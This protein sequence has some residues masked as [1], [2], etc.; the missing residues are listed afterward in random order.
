MHSPLIEIQQ[1]GRSSGRQQQFGI[2]DS[3]HEFTRVRRA[4]A[5]IAGR[6]ADFHDKSLRTNP[7]LSVNRQFM[8]TCRIQ[9]RV[10]GRTGQR[11]AHPQR[12]K[13]FGLNDLVQRFTLYFLQQESQHAKSQVVVVAYRVRRPVDLICSLAT[14]VDYSFLALIV[15]IMQINQSGSPDLTL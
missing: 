3:A 7:G 14:I 10:M 1:L 15:L 8:T 9:V 11:P 4:G 5:E 12:F 6:L 2:D 13:H